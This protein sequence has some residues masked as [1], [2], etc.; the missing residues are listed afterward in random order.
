[1]Q[2][3][4]ARPRLTAVLGA[5][6]IAFSAILVRVSHAE[7]ATAAVF[8]CLYA[9]P[10]LA[11]LAVRETR[12]EGPRPRRDRWLGVV[13]G[14]VFAI[15]L[16]CWH[17]AIH[18]V[19]AGLATVLGNLQ[20]VLVGPVAFIVLRERPGRRLLYAMPV[21][22]AGVVLISG[23]VGSGAYG[24]HPARGAV[25][26]VLTGISYACFI[27]VLRQASR[28]GQR[29][30]GALTDATAVAAV[31][32]AVI[33]LALG[34]VDL[35]PSWPAH[36]WLLLLALSSQ[37][38]G[39]LLI[40]SALSRLPAALGSVLLTIQPV[41]SVLLGVVLLGE[42]PSAVQFTGVALVLAGVVGASGVRPPRR[43]SA[44]RP[45]RGPPSAQAAAA[46]GTSP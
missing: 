26:G 19:G 13:A 27:L 46:R 8:R 6:T 24:S 9:T 22:L 21:V 14:V 32:A 11:L 10:I 5:L 35:V 38:L 37:V 34:H 43:F 25:F 39:W 40:M 18:D 16:L 42:R 28:G 7:P 3:L 29:T 41:G 31:A 15:D 20:V 17:Q 36:A 12:R 2:A 45:R 44:A 1:V 4:T 33:G 30:V 23:A